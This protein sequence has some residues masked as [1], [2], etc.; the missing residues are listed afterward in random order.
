MIFK[1]NSNSKE[2]CTYIICR[3]EDSVLKRF[4]LKHFSLNHDVKI[5]IDNL[6]ISYF[7]KFVELIKIDPKNVACR[8]F[9]LQLIEF[10]VNHIKYPE[11]LLPVKNKI[12]TK[13]RQRI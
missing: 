5:N 1:Y 10:S 2:C 7:L 6:F 9:I 4:F 8:L 13:N 12:V 3:E 11:H